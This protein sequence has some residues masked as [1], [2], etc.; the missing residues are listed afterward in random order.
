MLSSN[1]KPKDTKPYDRERIW[2]KKK[3]KDQQQRLEKNKKVE[4]ACKHLRQLRLCIANTANPFI[5]VEHEIAVAD[6]ENH[7]KQCQSFHLLFYK[8]SG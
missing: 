6:F 1:H 3:M 5:V 4:E 2:A 7:T 8:P